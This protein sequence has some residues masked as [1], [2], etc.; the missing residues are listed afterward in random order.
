MALI[1]SANEVNAMTLVY[2]KQQDLQIRQTH[3]RTQ[4]IDGLSLQI[5]G[6]IIA[7]L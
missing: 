5:F 7:G 6:M 1:N 2:V 3:V 4:K